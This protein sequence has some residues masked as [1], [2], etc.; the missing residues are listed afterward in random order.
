MT[1]PLDWTRADTAAALRFP[2]PGDDKYSRGVLGILTGSEEYPGAAVLGVE[3]AARAGA[4]LIRYRGAA[5]PTQLVLQRRPEVVT[6]PGQ[7]QAWLIG[8]GMP[9]EAARSPAVTAEM[10]AALAE[11]VPTVL[12]AGALSLLSSATGPVIITPHAGE[13]RTLFTDAGDEWVTRAEIMADPAGWAQRAA[14]RFGVTVLLKGH[15]TVT[16]AA[17]GE[18]FQVI[19]SSSWAATAGSGDVLGGIL[20]ALVAASSADILAGHT[21]LER[22]GAAAA[23]LHQAAAHQASQGGPVTALDIAG[24]VPGVIAGLSPE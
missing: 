2:G 14:V 3:G 9:G 19:A 12:D 15:T 6:L 8:S 20:G 24:S 5:T 7:V 21:S 10:L 22:V 1:I 11:A 18:S 13:L 17:N 23:F 4:G 16:A